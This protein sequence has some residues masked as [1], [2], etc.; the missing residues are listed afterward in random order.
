[1]SDFLQNALTENREKDETLGSAKG[2]GNDNPHVKV[3]GLAA[4]R[5]FSRHLLASG[6]LI[7]EA[8]GRRKT[9]CLP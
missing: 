3:N 8:G 6:L 7:E 2:R 5:S 1:M 4:S 9:A